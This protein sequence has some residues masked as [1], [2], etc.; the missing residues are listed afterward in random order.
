MPMSVTDRLVATLVAASRAALPAKFGAR[1]KKAVFQ[2]PAATDRLEA[3][4]ALMRAAYLNLMR[5]SLVGRL[6]EDPPLPACKVDGYQDEFR[7]NGWDWP[8]KAPSMIGAKRMNNVRSECERVIAAGVPGDFMEAG[9]WRGGACM[10]MRAVLKAYQITDRRVIAAD[11]FA[12]PPPP[13]KGIAADEGAD[14]HTY[15]DFAVPLEEVKAAFARY[16]LLDEQVVFLEGLF[17]DTL[18]A[19]PVETLAL[20]RLDGDMYESTMDGLVN[21][22]HKLS[23]GGTLIVDDYYLFEAHRQAVDEFRAA[24]RITDPITQVD[25]FGGY[26][27]KTIAATGASRFPSKGDT[28]RP[29]RAR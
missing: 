11:S 14:F 2:D 15:E 17:K 5:D 8:S 16:G 10:M 6:N 24:H 20:L 22:Y 12:G 7:E 3:D 23:S 27:I 18:P 21:L 19:A 1:I 4:T 9:V 28:A 26:W 13:S 29:P 25:H